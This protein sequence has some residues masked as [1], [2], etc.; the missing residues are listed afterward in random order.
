MGKTRRDSG[1]FERVSGCRVSCPMLHSRP[2]FQFCFL[3]QQMPYKGQGIY[4]S[5]TENKALQSWH[6]LTTLHGMLKFDQY[7]SVVPKHPLQI[8]GHA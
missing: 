4:T 3:E 5:R 2:S 7:T 8:W 1:S 6:K